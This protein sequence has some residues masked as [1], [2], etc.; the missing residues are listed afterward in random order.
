MRIAINATVLDCIGVSKSAAPMRRALEACV[1]G[2]APSIRTMG[3]GMYDR[4]QYS[5][6]PTAAESATLNDLQH[7]LQE[8]IPEFVL[9]VDCACLASRIQP[10]GSCTF[11][12]SVETVML[13]VEHWDKSVMARRLRAKCDR[14]AGPHS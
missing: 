14:A 13:E 4:P 6:G 11:A 5:G 8:L 10:G 3:S 9:S 1:E 2:Q 7:K 12:R